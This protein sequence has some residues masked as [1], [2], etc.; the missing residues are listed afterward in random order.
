MLFE[1]PGRRATVVQ[2]SG[3][4]SADNNDGSAANIWNLLED[5]G[6]DRSR[7]IVAWNVVPWYIGSEQRIRAA[8]PDDLSEARAALEELL[9]L[10]PDLR[11]VILFGK[12]AGEAWEQ[13]GLEIPTIRAPHPSPRNLNGRPHYRPKILNALMQARWEAGLA[14]MRPTAMTVSP[15]RLGAGVS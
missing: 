11:V 7:E 6:V 12:P 5:A 10:L 1:A 14:D 9:S 3:F 13:V 2:G 15:Q 8:T 4:I